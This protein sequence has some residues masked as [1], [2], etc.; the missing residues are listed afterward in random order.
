MRALVKIPDRGDRYTDRIKVGLIKAG[1]EVVDELRPEVGDV[2]LIW[3]RFTAYEAIASEFELAG[4][5]VLV[6]ENG[7]LGREWNGKTW[8]S[9]A[10]NHHNGAGWTPNLSYRWDDK[11]GFE[12]PDWRQN[13]GEIVALSQRGFGEKGIT[14]PKEWTPPINCRI[15]PH[16]GENQIISL[17]DDL[18]DARLVITWGS[19]AAIKAL[20]MGIPVI[21]EFKNWIGRDAATHVSNANFNN[22]HKGDRVIT[23]RKVFSAMWSIDE[24]EKGDPFAVFKYFNYGKLNK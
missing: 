11:Y 4:A 7:Y 9:I 24:I 12:L 16:P 6:F 17:N 19:G 21:Y 5:D 22:P 8:F 23:F 20:A 15:R 2:L 13:E 10:A 3:N 18:K 1:Y 14:M